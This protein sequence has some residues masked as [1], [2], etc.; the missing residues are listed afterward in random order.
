M[1]FPENRSLHT[2]ALYDCVSKIFIIPICTI[3]HHS[4][5][6]FLLISVVYITQNPPCGPFSLAASHMGDLY[7]VFCINLHTGDEYNLI[8]TEGS[9]Y[10]YLEVIRREN[11][12]FRFNIN[13]ILDPESGQYI[14]S[15]NET[16]NWIMLL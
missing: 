4:F 8:V 12:P 15:I 10:D 1:H 16:H 7:V 13:R 9:V 2:R 6:N 14:V 5:Q 11:N 3:I